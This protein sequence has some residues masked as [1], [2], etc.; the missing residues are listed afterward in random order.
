MPPT[1][2]MNPNGLTPLAGVVR[3]Q[4]DVPVQARIIIS[5]GTSARSHVLPGTHTVH[6]VPVL[7]LKPATSY[8]VQVAII[9][10]GQETVLGPVLHAVT[11]PLPDDFPHIEVLVSDPANMEPGYTMINRISTR[12]SA[13]SGRYSIIFDNAGNVVWFANAGGNNMR[14]MPN[15]NIIFLFG[16][17]WSEMDLLGNVTSRPLEVPF[18]A[19]HHELQPTVNGTLLSLDME[20][21]EVD[22]YP[23][24]ETDPSAPRQP[25]TIRDDPIVEF[26]LDGTLLGVW[27]LAELIDTG[28]IGYL[29]LNVESQLGARDWVHANAVVHDPSDDSLIVSIRHQDAVIK[30]S[31][32][33]GQIRWILGPHANWAPGFQPYLLEP[34]GAPFEWQ[35]HQHAPEI[36]E[37]GTLLVYDNGNFRASPFDG[38]TPLANSATFTRAVEYEIDEANMQVR[39]VWQYGAGL[40]E[41]IYAGFLGDADRLAQTGNT[42]LTLGGTQYIGGQQTGTIGR[43]AVTVRII[44]V[45]HATPANKVFDLAIFETDPAAV[46]QV[47]RAER[48]PSLYPLDVDSDGDGVPDRNDNCTTAANPDQR[49]SDADGYGNLCD[50]DFNGDGFTNALDL[51]RFKAEFF[52]TGALHTDM[53]GDGVVNSLD[54]GLFKKKFFLPVGPAGFTPL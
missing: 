43:G 29:S 10:N 33:T 15:G 40:S 47:Y 6:A 17:Q 27:R 14:Q 42:L 45:D 18:N 9:E 13:T 20:R 23:T 8:S 53:N 34:V 46:L 26:A 12:G 38:T 44:E 51:G 36:T 7:G 16:N 35:Y 1:L 41:R 24:S 11:P 22:S 54:L 49:D 3:F 28:R 19:L 25:A 50:A 4:T 48:I 31:R 39:Q 21:I 32:R 30:F 37:A 2:T 5:D 52:E